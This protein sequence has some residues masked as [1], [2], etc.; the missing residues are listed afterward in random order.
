MSGSDKV[1]AFCNAKASES[2][3]LVC[4][5][6]LLVCGQLHSQ[7]MPLALIAVQRLSFAA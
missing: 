6:I 2:A 7:E 5:D 3:K 4:V 1:L